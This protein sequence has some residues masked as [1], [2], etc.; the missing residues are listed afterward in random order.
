MLRTAVILVA[1]ASP[2]LADVPR[3]GRD[4]VAQSRTDL[5]SARRK[6]HELTDKLAY[7]RDAT[8]PDEVRRTIEERSA[9]CV[10]A[11]PE[12]PIPPKRGWPMPALLAGGAVAL[13]SAF[14]LARAWD[15]RRRRG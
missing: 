3:D 13:L 4:G 11:Y 10:A 5:E 14:A 12:P 1:L 6:C 8:P 7:G 2:A 15:N 9:V